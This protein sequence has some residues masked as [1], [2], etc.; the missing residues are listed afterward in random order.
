M[1][2]PRDLDPYIPA[3]LLGQLAEAPGARLHVLD[4]TVLFADV[5]GFTNLSERLT[6]RGREGAEELVET[7]GAA[8]GVLLDVAHLKGGS[9]LKL[10]GD[11][12]LLLFDGPDH[13]ARACGAAVGMRD[14]L[15]E[16]GRIRTSAG[17]VT[18]RISQG[19]HTG[20]AHLVLVGESHREQILAG[21]AASV[22]TLME[23]AAGAGEI[24][25][26]PA[27]AALLP[28]RCVGGAKGPGRRLLAAPP[29]PDR[30]RIQPAVPPTREQVAACL[31]TEVRA[32]VLAG[33]HPPEHRHVTTAFVQWRGTDELLAREGPDAAV[34]ALEEFVTSVQRAADEQQ[35]CFLE[36]DVD[37]T[38][39]KV[40]LTAG[41]PRMVGDDEERMLLALRRIVESDHVLP[42]RIGVNRGSVFTGDVGTPFRRTYSVM[43]DAVN[44]A[45]RVM[46]K[47]PIGEIYTTAGALERSATR[48]RVAALEPFMVKGKR[49]P[50]HAWSVGPAIGSRAREGVALRFPLIGRDRELGVLR[51]ALQ[52]A[53]TGSGRFVEIVGEAG[54]GKSRLVDALIDDASG[55]TLLRAT[56]EA[57]TAATPYA[58]WKEALG[59][60][61]GIAPDDPD[62]LAFV[63][64]GRAAV[65]ADPSLAPWLPLLATAIGIDGPSSRQVDELAPEFRLAKLTEVFGRFLRLRLPGPTLLRFEDA[66]CMDTASADLLRTGAGMLGEV[67][68]LV[69][70]TRRDA[71]GAL[72][73]EDDPHAVRLEPGPLEPAD[74]LA[75]AEL[76]TDAAPIPPHALRLAAERSGG[77]PQFLRD[78]LREAAVGTDGALP[79]SIETAAMAQIDRLEHHDRALVRRAAVLGQRFHPEQLAEVLDTGEEPPDAATWGRLSS[80]FAEDSDGYLRF[81]R[82]VVRDAGYAGLPYRVRRDLHAAVA[83]R[84]EREVGHDPADLAALLS[85]HASRAGDHERAWRYARVA[86]DRARARLAYADA[87]V[88]DRRALDAAR[89]LDVDAADLA[90]VW[91]ALGSSL[92]HTGRLEQAH[93]ALGAARRLVGGD[94]VREAELLLRHA[95]VAER[96]GRVLPAVR[97]AQRGLRAVEDRDDVQARASRA[98]LT[99]M[100]AT[101]RQREGRTADAIALCRQ[102]IADAEA[103]GEDRALAHACFI[104]D[105]ALFDAGRPEEAVH[106]ARAL[107]IFER[108]GDL[109]RQAAV[110]NN[111]GGLAYHQGRWADAVDLYRR[112]AASSER[113]GDVA[114]AAFG[115]CNVGEVLSDQGRLEEAEQRLRRALRVWRGSGYDWGTAF[116]SAQLGREAMRAGRHT[117]AVGLLEEALASFRRLRA[118]SDAELVGAYLAEALAFAGAPE[119]ALGAAD[120][121]LRGARRSAPLL[122]RVRGFA[123]A[124]IGDLGPAADAFAVS[125]SVARGEG[126]VYELAVTLDAARMLR[127]RTG[128][129]PVPAD[130]AE[131]DAILARL[132]VAA[133]PAAPIAP[134]AASAAQRSLSRA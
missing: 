70:V 53:R 55:F 49:D 9:L 63:R 44:L 32:H 38:G 95:E 100:L 101:V 58:A 17:N 2:G 1:I 118:M 98:R 81:R 110:L 119:D 39:G 73:A 29:A 104:L 45:A 93:Q 33:P 86:G 103:A 76:V 80:V 14:L 25:V 131:C 22:S 60:V 99:S 36:T 127:A 106:S 126:N 123:L 83:Q 47:T 46:G 40:M 64:L 133:L 115:D 13:L 6:R 7:I 71:A 125:A 11:A 96:A 91:E 117:E 84:L 43:G 12:L 108:L 35:V 107:E 134:A 116:A 48:F 27:A 97:W 129:P 15:R 69:M 21:P 20:E 122:H 56:C 65:A 66:Q 16:A 130:D 128:A 8:F 94:A 26:S 3:V 4:A 132:G 68:W 105:W 89:W 42:I 113:A 30:P 112:G 18:L 24:I 121:L 92:A 5:S 54:I 59:P 77:S 75:L 120:R 114:N 88:F 102:A 78:L 87:A 51:D 85:L 23:K 31:S 34:A 10:A 41:A 28:R 111:L 72:I 109:D 82:A 79:D 67:P 124:A 52:S 37:P 19:L 57:Y 74:I 90:A 61:V 50:V 62:D